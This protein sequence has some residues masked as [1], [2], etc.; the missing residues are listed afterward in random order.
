MAGGEVGQHQEEILTS[1]RRRISGL[2]RELD[3]RGE[4][5]ISTGSDCLDACLPAAGLVSGAMHEWVEQTGVGGGGDW[6]SL[7]AARQALE[8]N[9]QG[10]LVVLDLAGT[11]YPPAALALGLEAGRII[12]LRPANRADGLWAIDQALRSPAV[13]AV[14]G[15]LDSLDDRE[16]RR[17]QLA[18]EVGNTLG[19]WTRPQAALRAPS[20]AETRWLV[21]GLGGGAEEEQSQRRLEV[22]LVRCRGGQTGRK[23]VLEIDSRGRV[24]DASSHNETAAMPLVAQLANPAVARQRPQRRLA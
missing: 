1:L 19:L 13:A 5:S 15:R 21:R 20:W 8:V 16:A 12:V 22:R 7:L 18:A 11:F 6:L 24:R 10:H 14:W 9:R 23:F 2:E 4:Q 17:L 3:E